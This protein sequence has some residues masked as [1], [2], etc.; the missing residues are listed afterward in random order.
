[1]GIH[2]S[3]RER[4]FQTESLPR[5]GIARW[6]VSRLRVAAPDTEMAVGRAII[7]DVMAAGAIQEIELQDSRPK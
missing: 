5:R 3:K 1:M 4:Q 7:V 6:P 2:Q